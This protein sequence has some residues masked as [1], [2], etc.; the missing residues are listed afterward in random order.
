MVGFLGA[1]A[2][3]ILAQ[4]MPRTPPVALT[5]PLC[6]TSERE[7]YWVRSDDLCGSRSVPLRRLPLLTYL[8]R[9]AA[10]E[11]HKWATQQA[12]RWPIV[13]GTIDM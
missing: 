4:G 9:A 2:A 8:S 12:S 1:K 10:R 13:S 7:A 3:P 6:E 11:A 5:A